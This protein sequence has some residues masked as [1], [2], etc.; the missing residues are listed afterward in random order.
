MQLSVTVITSRMYCNILY[1]RFRVTE[2]LQ[3]CL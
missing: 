2:R 3:V 1:L